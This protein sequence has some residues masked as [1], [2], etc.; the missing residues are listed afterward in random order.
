M[1]VVFGC[2]VVYK[3]GVDIS[4]RFTLLRAFKVLEIIEFISGKDIWCCLIH[5]QFT[6]FTNV[7]NTDIQK[8]RI[9]G[10]KLIAQCEIASKRQNQELD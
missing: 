7:Q 5:R 1:L 4:P 2:K 3:V 10:N 8:F 9:E 6:S